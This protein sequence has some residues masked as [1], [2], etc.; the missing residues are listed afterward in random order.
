MQGGKKRIYDQEVK[1]YKV[2]MAFDHEG[3]WELFGADEENDICL[4]L[5]ALKSTSLY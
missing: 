3:R 4:S 2:A 1:L 5:K